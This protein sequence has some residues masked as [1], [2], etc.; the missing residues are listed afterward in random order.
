MKIFFFCF[1]TLFLAGF[2]VIPEENFTKSLPER[3]KHGQ[4]L[5]KLGSAA[6]PLI[7]TPTRAQQQRTRQNPQA[8]AL[9]RPSSSEDESEDEIITRRRNMRDSE[10]DDDCGIQMKR[11]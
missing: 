9:L 7:G 6:S 1:L 4:P 8:T 3:A 2:R 11:S 5:L 10:S